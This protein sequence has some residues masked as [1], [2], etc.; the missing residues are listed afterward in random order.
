MCSTLTY[1]SEAWNLTERTSA[2][3]NGCNARCLSHITGRSAHTEVSVSIRILDLVGLGEIR[4][5]RYR[6][7]G[8]ILRM[9]NT[10][11]VKEAVRVQFALNLPGNIFLDT[12]DVSFSQQETLAS[13][14]D[15]WRHGV[16][17]LSHQ[18]IFDEQEECR[19]KHSSNSISI[20]KYV[21]GCY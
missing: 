18:S 7:L 3:L 2:M 20:R 15:V 19:S 16:P 11:R 9:P 14:R 5:R 6:W 12:P 13:D 17:G 1:G 21:G 10:R 8:H 4:Q